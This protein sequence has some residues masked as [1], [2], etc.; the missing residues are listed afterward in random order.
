MQVNENGVERER[1]NSFSSVTVAYAPGISHGHALAADLLRHTS[2]RERTSRRHRAV[3][4]YRTTTRCW[5]VLSYQS[6]PRITLDV[7][8]TKCWQ[9]CLSCEDPR[10]QTFRARG[11]LCRKQA[12]DREG[13]ADRKVRSSLHSTRRIC[14]DAATPQRAFTGATG[15]S[16][17]LL[18]R[19]GLPRELYRA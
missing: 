17:C 5:R 9:Q 4:Q 15:L 3:I 12:P 1:I 8:T 18:R 19:R 10:L 6:L 7:R 14:P 13:L 2:R 11:I 16:G